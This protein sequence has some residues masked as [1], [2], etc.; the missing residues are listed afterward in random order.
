M[1]FDSHAHPSAQ[2]WSDELDAMREQGVGGFVAVGT[3]VESSTEMVRL[4]R[5]LR[6]E[7]P[8]LTIGVA[9]GIH[10]HDADSAS[11]ESLE[12]LEGM[13]KENSEIVCGVGE[14]GLDLFYEYSNP[15]HQEAA[16]RAQIALAKRF[17]R[18]LV[19]HT[20]DAWE[21]T[22]RIFDDEGV[23][24]RLIMH[25]FVGGPLEARRSLDYGAYLSFSG[26]ATFK[27]AEDVRQAFLVAPLERVLVETDA[28]YLAPV[29]LRGRP[30]H[31]GN[32]AITGSF[33][34]ELRGIEPTKFAGRTWQNT[35]EVFQLQHK[36]R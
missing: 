25:C 20:R 9:V 33:L 23:P 35:I 34:A 31:I 18:T 7:H 12:T 14:C 26:I 16:F 3:S 10:P 13:I 27:N 6:Q 2:G 30:N 15:Q 17:D 24:D 21:D 5:E 4:S 19:I 11:K 22:F 29:P 28:P 1:W 36:D 8:E 32:V